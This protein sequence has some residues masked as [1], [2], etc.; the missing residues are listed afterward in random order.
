[1]NG[2]RHVSGIE[3]QAGENDE[4]RGYREPRGEN[5][6]PAPDRKARRFTE[7]I[8]QLFRD[9]KA[10]LTHKTPILHP[11][12]RRRKGDPQGGFRLAVKQVLRRVQRSIFDP[13]HFLSERPDEMDE[14]QRLHLWHQNNQEGE[15]F[16]ENAP[17]NPEPQEHLS[18]QL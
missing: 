13:E 18:L 12:K 7:G 9:V 16:Y 6:S 17:S 4:S 2:R 3:R 14:S 15:Y 11:A 10:A 1:M 5:Q 8:R